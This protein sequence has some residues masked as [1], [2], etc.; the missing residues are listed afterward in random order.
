MNL[1]E[2]ILICGALGTAFIVGSLSIGYPLIQLYKIWT[3]TKENRIEW[4][5]SELNKRE[6]LLKREENIRRLEEEAL[7]TA[8]AEAQR[9]KIQ[10]EQLQEQFLRVKQ[11]HE[12]L[13]QRINELEKDIYPTN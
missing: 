1:G 2:K 10:Y 9:T 5:K 4:E 13:N 11:A 12:L 6:V 7:K 3:E 8:P